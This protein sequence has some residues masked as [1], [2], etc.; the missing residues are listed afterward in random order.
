[1]SGEKPFNPEDDEVTRMGWEDT[2]DKGPLSEAD[3]KRL[4]MLQGLQERARRA[5]Q[6]PEVTRLGVGET[7]ELPLD[8]EPFDGERAKVAII[9]ALE[10]AI[11]MYGKE[12]NRADKMTNNED[13]RMW[14]SQK[15]NQYLQELATAKTYLEQ[16]NAAAIVAD[17]DL[18]H[19]L[20]RELR[21]PALRALKKLAEAGK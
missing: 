12:M 15:L 19:R 8:A 14:D 5:E 11:A 17:T 7:R 21:G 9:K 20:T 3:Q 13:V 4:E 6:P 1:M 16:G 10:S 2:G 18:M